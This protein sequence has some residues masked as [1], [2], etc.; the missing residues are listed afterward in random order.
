MKNILL[1]PILSILFLPIYAQEK[2]EILLLGTYHFG[3]N[4]IDNIKVHGDAILSERKQ[5]ELDILLEKLAFFNPQKIYV[6]NVPDQQALWDSIYREHLHGRN[7]NYENEIYQI[8]IKL[9]AKLKLNNGVTCVDWQQEPTQTFLQREYSEFS[10]K[11]SE[12]YMTNNIP[13][14]E[15]M[16]EY[17]KQVEQEITDFNKKI[18]SLTLIEVFKH[19]NTKDYLNNMF[20][21]NVSSFLDIDEHHLNV[22]W[23]QNNMFRNVHVYQNVIQ[24]I[25]RHKPKRVLILYGAGHIKALQNYLEVHPAVKISDT[26]KV[27]E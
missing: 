22:F 2:T 18:P 20:Y 13:D 17:E 10:E 27:L 4:T 23:S 1:I 14:Q 24:D 7:F 11:I 21:G 3:G 9:A 25:L 16:S 12:Y 6:E 5:E 15:A 19:L 8:G 26:E